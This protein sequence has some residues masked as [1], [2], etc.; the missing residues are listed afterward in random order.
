M[1]LAN[2]IAH[3]QFNSSGMSL[4]SYITHTQFHLPAQ[5]TNSSGMPLASHLV[6]TRL[7]AQA[8]NF[9]KNAI[10]QPYSSCPNRL[11]STGIQFLQECQQPATQ[12]IPNSN[13]QHIQ[14]NFLRNVI[15]QPHS[16]YPILFAS[17]TP[18]ASHIA[19]FQLYWPQECHQPA[20]QLIYIQFYLP[21]ERHW[22][23]T[24]LLSVSIYLRNTS[25]QPYSSY[26]TLFTSSCS[27]FP[28][29][30]QWP[31]TYLIQNSTCQL[32]QPISRGMPLASHRA[33]THLSL[34]AQVANF[35]R[36]PIGQPQSSY[37]FLVVST[38]SQFP[39]ECHWPA[40]QRIPNIS[41]RHMQ[42]NSPEM[43]LASHTTH[44]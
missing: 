2:H 30:C 35:P 41:C 34:R 24:Q 13:C 28:E 8:A 23:A 21:Q 1:P 42:P 19:H 36:N 16:L 9:L 32:M 22:P 37:T 26:Q 15:S 38:G 44:S 40:R 20:T 17:G 12:L 10:D 3:N 27:R 14:P 29:E 4:A 39:Q 33:H 25:G 7:R 6:H 31:A 43:P 18:L 11:A 5:V